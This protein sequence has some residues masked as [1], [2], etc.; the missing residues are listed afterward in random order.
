[1][2]DGQRD[3]GWGVLL[4]V[5]STPDNIGAICNGVSN[6]GSQCYTL[7]V[8]LPCAQGST[9][10]VRPPQLFLVSCCATS[11]V[12]RDYRCLAVIASGASDHQVMAILCINTRTN[13]KPYRSSLCQIPKQPNESSIPC[14]VID[15][16]LANSPDCTG[17]R[18]QSEVLKGWLF[19]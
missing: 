14:Y 3:W 4:S 15:W 2:R 9:S 1:M 7:D 8:L 19:R 6:G 12:H 18:L 16:L 17:Q 13:R 10:G 11:R 5:I